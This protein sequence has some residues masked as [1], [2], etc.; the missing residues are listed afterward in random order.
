MKAKCWGRT[1]AKLPPPPRPEPRLVSEL[2]DWLRR[3]EQRSPEARIDLGLARARTVLDALALDLSS[4]PVITVGGT[5]GKGSVV[6]MLEAMCRAAGWRTLAYS[7]PHLLDFSERI[8]IDS[9]PA[10]QDQIASALAQ[11]EQARGPV[12]LTYFEHV[13]LSALVLAAREQPDVLLL[14]VGLGGRLDA[15]NVI[16]ADVAVITSIGLDHTEWLGPT[17]LSIGCEKAGIARP[18]RPLIVGERRLPRGLEPVLG[19][20]GARL[21]LAG[22]DFRWRP[23]GTRHLQIKHKDRIW[24][25][26]RPTLS[27]PFQLGN[28]ACAVL[29]LSELGPRLTVSDEHLAAGLQQ[30]FVPGRLQLVERKPDVWLDVAHNGP[31]ARALAQALGPAPRGA[32]STA[33]FSALADKDVAAIGRALNPCF[34]RWL[35]AGLDGQRACPASELAARLLKTPVAGAVET[36]ESVAGGLSQALDDSTRDDRIVVLG[37]FRTVAAAANLLQQR[38]L[39]R[40]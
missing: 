27:G 2:Q 16:D 17:R 13:T 29:A 26:P 9:R 11:V 10:A 40:G 35:V 28:A 30:A 23:T 25:L 24:R 3:L 7:S 1:S 38:R 19:A 32:R 5:N 8:R 6:A 12:P 37:S 22:R 39:E 14:E 34:D 21:L 31:S 15:V 36:V 4:I 33:I 18:E 20:T